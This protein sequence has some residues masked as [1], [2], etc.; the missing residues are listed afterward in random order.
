MCSLLTHFDEKLLAV[1]S[2]QIKGL[3]LVCESN[4]GADSLDIG[5][6][7]HSSM[8]GPACAADPH[9]SYIPLDNLG[10]IG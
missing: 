3:R 4:D 5:D 2:E 9:T 8:D 6:R 1:G 7:N 10:W